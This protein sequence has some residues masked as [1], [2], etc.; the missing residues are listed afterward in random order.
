MTATPLSQDLRTATEQAHRRAEHS[1][2]MADLLEGRA[3]AAAYTAL[4]GQL[5]H[6]YRTLEDAVRRHADHPA[7]S[8]LVDARLDRTGRL[9]ADLHALGVD[10]TTVEVLPATRAYTE[11]LGEADA[12]ALVAHHYVRYLGDLSGGQAIATLVERHYGIT[13]AVTFYDFADLGKAKPYKDDYR[14]RLDA[15]PV[16]GPERERLL[17]EA[18]TA[19]ELNQ[20]LFADL[21]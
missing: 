14:A 1:P 8:P 20:A 10:P 4:T 2:F 6:V 21:A 5:L 3:S 16:A 15:L 9:E 7:L 13:D 17:A 19:F 12:V 18:V 11:R